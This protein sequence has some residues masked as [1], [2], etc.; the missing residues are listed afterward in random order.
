MSFAGLGRAIRY[1]GHYKNLAVPAYLFL[2]I[3]TGATLLVP[4][5]VQ[6]IIDALTNGFIAQ[7]LTKIPAAFQ[8]QALPLA[9]QNWAGR[10][11]NTLK[12]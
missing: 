5:M 3:A 10:W 8:A 4:Q 11:T 6:N 12:I 2:L 1:L 9:L 7:Q